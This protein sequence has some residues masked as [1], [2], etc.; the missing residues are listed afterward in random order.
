MQLFRICY[1]L[2]IV[3]NPLVSSH[4]VKDMKV[5]TTT[6]HGFSPFCFLVYVC[7]GL[8]V[9]EGHKRPTEKPT[10]SVKSGEHNSKLLFVVPSACD[11]Y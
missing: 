4:A 6:S 1:G 5:Q 2:F 3:L 10:G 11:V 8:F 7:G 9:Q